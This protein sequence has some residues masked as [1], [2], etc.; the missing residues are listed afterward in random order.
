MAIKWCHAS[1][2]GRILRPLIIFFNGYFRSRST[3]YSCR[4]RA[5]GRLRCA[6]SA[7]NA[8]VEPGTS[9]LPLRNFSVDPILKLNRVSFGRKRKKKYN[10]GK[11][12]YIFDA[13]ECETYLPEIS[14]GK[15]I[16]CKDG[17]AGRRGAFRAAP[18]RAPLLLSCK[19]DPHIVFLSYL[20]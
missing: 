20:E 16:V 15:S 10:I 18:R 1:F 13:T 5:V 17:V 2:T 12:M 7:C 11:S 6:R 9:S 4:Y 3:N 19:L 14:D 8:G